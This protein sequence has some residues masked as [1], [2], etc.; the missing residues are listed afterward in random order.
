MADLFDLFQ[1]NG[2]ALTSK[3][4]VRVVLAGRN[5]TI[6]D[7]VAEY[8]IEDA[9]TELIV[10]KFVSVIDEDKILYTAHY[11]KDFDRSAA[12]FCG[13][14]IDEWTEVIPTTEETTGLTF[15]YD[16]P[17]TEPPQTLLLATPSDFTG[18][19]DWQDLVDTLRETLDLAKIR[20]V[21]PQHVDTTPYS[22]F[23]PAIL[24][25]VATKPI[26]TTL[27]FAFNNGIQFKMDE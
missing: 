19:W 23:L 25:E 26:T 24:S 13:V 8:H 16:R 1:L 17:N 18:H 3:A 4:A 7:S 20:A 21:E 6:I 27:N 5:W 12:L 15:H 9:G 2:Q 10:Y 14:L 11:H 22:N